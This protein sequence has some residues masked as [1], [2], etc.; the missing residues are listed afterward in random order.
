MG[1]KVRKIHEV[2]GV[3]RDW[4]MWGEASE[5]AKPYSDWISVDEL[6]SADQPAHPAA[7]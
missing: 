2:T 1:T 3:D 6:R 7:A 4:L 5:G